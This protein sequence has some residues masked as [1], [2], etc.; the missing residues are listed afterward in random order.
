VCVLIENPISRC[1]RGGPKRPLLAGRDCAPAGPELAEDARPNPRL[2]D[3]VPKLPDEAVGQLIGRLRP[4]LV[5]MELAPIPAGTHHDVEAGG[6]SQSGKAL[7]VSPEHRRR[8]VHE[9]VP[10]R[11][12]ICP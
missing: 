8:Q 12:A 4:D 10:A 2:P 5:R 9:A 11:V 1:A 3:P 6:A 7:R